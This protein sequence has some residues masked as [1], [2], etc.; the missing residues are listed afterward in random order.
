LHGDLR[1]FAFWH[2]GVI[3]SPVRAYCQQEDDFADDLA[4]DEFEGGDDNP[5]AGGDAAGGGGGADEG[6]TEAANAGK[7]MDKSNPFHK[8]PESYSIFSS[9]T[10][11]RYQKKIKAIATELHDF[12]EEHQTLLRQRLTYEELL[13]GMLYPGASRLLDLPSARENAR[14]RARLLRAPRS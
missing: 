3:S 1:A 2:L 4:D 5:V 11:N 6:G 7:Q 12:A 10:D 8:D 13:Q 14:C 9:I